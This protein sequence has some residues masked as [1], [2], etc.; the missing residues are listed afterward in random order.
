M[1]RKGRFGQNYPY[2]PFVMPEK[3]IGMTLPFNRFQH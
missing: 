1:Q 3:I 2:I